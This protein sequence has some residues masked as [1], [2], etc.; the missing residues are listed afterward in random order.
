MA[1][2]WLSNSRTP[3]VFLAII[4]CAAIAA[5]Y[6][7]QPR[8]EHARYRLGDQWQSFDHADGQNA[9][10][11]AV[12]IEFD[13]VLSPLAGTTFI[14]HP[15]SCARL[16]VNNARITT[17]FCNYL[18]APVDLSSY[19]HS[20]VNRVRAEI[21]HEGGLLR[22]VL[23]PSLLNPSLL[24]AIGLGL[25][26][27]ALIMQLLPAA[28][29]DARLFATPA[30]CGVLLRWLYAV[31]TPYFVRAWDWDGHLEYITHVAKHWTI[32]S[33]ASG[34]E[35]YQPPLYYFAAAAWA[36]AWSPTAPSTSALRIL[37]V[38]LSVAAMLAGFWIARLLFPSLSERRERLIFAWI[39]A[40]FPGLVFFGSR[41][42]NDTLLTTISLLCVALLILW[43]RLP[44]MKRWCALC[45]GLGL[46]VLTKMSIVPL[47]LTAAV[48][49]VLHPGMDARRKTV[50]ALTG[51]A[52]LAAVAG[53]LFV[54]RYAIEHQAT[55]V[56]V[57][58]GDAMKADNTARNLLTF[59]PVWVLRRPFNWNWNDDYRRQIFWE[60]LL[61]SS[62]VGEWVHH[63][64]ATWPLRLLL[65]GSMAGLLLAATGLVKEWRHDRHGA[66]P[67][68]VLIVA[69]LATI[70]GY[71]L[72]GNIWCQDF[73]FVPFI[74]PALLYSALR[75]MSAL[76][77]PLA[78][79]AS[80]CAGAFVALSAAFVLLVAGRGTLHL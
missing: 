73:R 24:L 44:S 10:A 48:C 21:E 79:A 49:L 5:L 64:I 62:F 57:Q 30:V 7:A 19:L 22:F 58:T 17:R 13:L 39:I 4:A 11:G 60:Y 34:W 76:P 80:V 75:A 33:A 8:V 3:N 53:W 27:L 31:S 50:I 61:K 54:L 41:V 29:L 70:F 56:F 77:R 65:A 40:V 35:T 52:V 67:I 18:G 66:L 37:S 43:W 74:L 55:L 2:K 15:S 42:S 71:R 26:V 1:R 78:Q 6:S 14:V 12:V 36:N 25:A 28:A 45:V 59:N 20:G 63:P 72:I 32:P 16:S 23:V 38:L 47:L 51:A 68:V 9:R 69:S 46:G